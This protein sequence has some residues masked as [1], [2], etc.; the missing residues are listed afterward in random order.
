MND[1]L[2]KN[3]LGLSQW[4]FDPQNP[5]T[6]RVAVN[7][8]WQMIFGKGLVAT[9][10]DFGVQGQLPSHPELLDWLAVSFSENWDVRA[11]LKKMILSETYQQQ[12]VSNATLDQKDPNNLLLGRANATRL[13]A[14]IIRDNAL[15]ISGLLNPK[16]GGESVRPYQPKGLWKEKNNFSTFLLEYKESEGEDLYRRGLY[17]FIRRTS[18]PPNMLTFDATSREICTVKREIT[19]TPLQAL[20]LLNDPQFFEA[21]RI[22]AE[23]MIKSKETLEEQ[24]THGFRLATSRFPKKE[25][26]NI[27]IDLYNSQY[28]YYRQNSDKAYQVLSVGQKPR[29]MNIYSVKTAAM[30]MVANTLLN[31]NETYTKR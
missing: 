18:P 17:T 14:E 1:D 10:N 16:V 2:P 4:L 5:L 3:R 19:S 25:E 13:P 28:Q 22:F 21:S 31:H 26:L 29:D 24:I 20:V 30:T 6:A 12:S 8:Y 27:L 9:P 11:L 23:R 7:R 15:K